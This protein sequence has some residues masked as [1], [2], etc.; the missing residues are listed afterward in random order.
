MTATAP[1]TLRVGL[2]VTAMPVQH[3]DAGDCMYRLVGSL[4]RLEIGHELVIF[5][6]RPVNR[7]GWGTPAPPHRI[8]PVAAAERAPKRLLAG[9]PSLA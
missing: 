9:R 3:A 1:R 4:L 8:E 2:D 7:E 5:F 6:T